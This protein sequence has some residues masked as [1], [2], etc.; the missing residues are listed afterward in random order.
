MC[1]CVCVYVCVCVC[2][3]V[4][5]N[6]CLCVYLHTVIFVIFI[7]NA[8]YVHVPLLLSAGYIIRY[9]IWITLQPENTIPIRRCF[10]MIL[11]CKLF[12]FTLYIRINMRRD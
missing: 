3:C 2:V 12:I 6:M 8:V 11:E 9:M 10:S 7:L 1:V 5:I 4:C